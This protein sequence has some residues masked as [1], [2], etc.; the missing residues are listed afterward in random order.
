M[1]YSNSNEYNNTC[2]AVVGNASFH[3]E[4][5]PAVLITSLFHF[6]LRH[7]V[8][9]TINIV[10]YLLLQQLSILSFICCY[11]NYQYRRFLIVII[12]GYDFKEATL[13]SFDSTDGIYKAVE[14]V[15]GLETQITKPT[16]WLFYKVKGTF[17][18]KLDQ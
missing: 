16:T 18:E 13:S 3:L 4:L 6:R 14:D 10:V 5:S 9:K 17:E 15:M 7:H 8:T 12:K 1:K 2:S 11:N